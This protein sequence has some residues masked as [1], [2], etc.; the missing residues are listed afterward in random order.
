MCK[1]WGVRWCRCVD[2]CPFVGAHVATG[3]AVA[4]AIIG[5]G[6][7]SLIRFKSDAIAVSAARSVGGINGNTARVEF[8]C[9]G[10]AAVVA[11]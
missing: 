9:I 3:T 6:L 4:I 7:R 11:Q 10:V 8:V 5:S 1:C 2:G